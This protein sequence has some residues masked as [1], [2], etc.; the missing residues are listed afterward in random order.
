[1]CACMSQVP[2]DSDEGGSSHKARHPEVGFLIANLF[3]RQAAAH[4]F[5]LVYALV[6]L[7][8]CLVVVVIRLHIQ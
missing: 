5:V 1:M 8:R 3:I 4:R 7:L 6:I 2:G